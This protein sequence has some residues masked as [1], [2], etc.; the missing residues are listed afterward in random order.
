MTYHFHPLTPWP[1]L[2]RDLSWDCWLSERDSFWFSRDFR[3]DSSHDRRS[4]SF[5]IS[6]SSSLILD[7]FWTTVP[8]SC[9]IWTTKRKKEMLIVGK[10]Y[11]NLNN[12]DTQNSHWM[13][14]QF[15]E[16]WCLVSATHRTNIM[17]ICHLTKHT[18]FYTLNIWFIEI[19]YWSSDIKQYSKFSWCKEPI[20]LSIYSIDL[21]FLWYGD[22]W[23]LS[24]HC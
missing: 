11:K 2:S 7:V 1:T 22:L 16:Q 4:F 6:S 13:T 9:P 20:W 23:L 10:Q 5:L 17:F 3:S 15:T 14:F 19:S 21:E 24:D 8:S 12:S 18:L